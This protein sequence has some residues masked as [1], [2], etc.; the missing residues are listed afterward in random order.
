MEYISFCMC[1]CV[2]SKQ[3][4]LVHQI[5]KWIQLKSF[6]S[7]NNESQWGLKQHCTPLGKKNQAKKV[8]FEKTW[9]WIKL[10]QTIEVIGVKNNTIPHWF[11]FFF[12][13]FWKKVLNKSW[14]HFFWWTMLLNSTHITQT[15][16]ERESDTV[17]VVPFKIS[18]PYWVHSWPMGHVCDLLAWSMNRTG[19]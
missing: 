18:Y 3:S 14:I 2:N 12:F 19:Q 4:T 16:Q 17:T 8:S 10:I 6:M 15:Q 9:S 11:F 1:V 13:F 5:N 7:P